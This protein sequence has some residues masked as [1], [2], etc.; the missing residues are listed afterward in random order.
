MKISWNL[1]RRPSHTIRQDLDHNVYNIAVYNVDRYY[2]TYG[3]SLPI[4]NASLGN[5]TFKH[6]KVLYRRFPYCQ[7]CLPIR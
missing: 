4:K 1:D 5:L 3:I 2:Q 6:Y 7:T